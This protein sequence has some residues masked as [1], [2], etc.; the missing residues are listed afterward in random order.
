MRNLIFFTV[1]VSFLLFSCSTNKLVPNSIFSQ[2]IAESFSLVK[3][4]M[5]EIQF[6]SD[7]SENLILKPLMEGQKK[8]FIQPDGG[9][10]LEQEGSLEIVIPKGTPGKLIARNKGR[11]DFLDISFDIQNPNHTLRFYLDTEG[12]FS[13]TEKEIIYGTKKYT[14][15]GGKLLYFY[16]VY[17]EG[18]KSQK[19]LTGYKVKPY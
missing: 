7:T 16:H 12:G 4:D 2:E 19:K 6:F 8:S 10:I 5:T 3:K 18:Q 1:A 13:L 9:V 15:N 17:L 14:V 11:L